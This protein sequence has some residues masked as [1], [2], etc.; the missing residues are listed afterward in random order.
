M[1][2]N[3]IDF[4][5]A[6]RLACLT[7]LR[8]LTQSVGIY[9]VA[10]VQLSHQGKIS[11]EDFWRNLFIAEGTGWSYSK[12]MPTNDR[13]LLYAGRNGMP[14]DCPA[15]PYGVLE[16]L[17]VVKYLYCGTTRVVSRKGSLSALPRTAAASLTS[18]VS[19]TKKEWDL[20]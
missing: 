10:A 4:N 9:L 13:P 8:N 7:H 16:F 15:N 12:R 1:M 17:D 18:S 19:P 6:Q 20:E 2:E 14:T 5:D 11:P 3:K